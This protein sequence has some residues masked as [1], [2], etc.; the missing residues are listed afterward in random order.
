MLEMAVEPSPSDVR[1]VRSCLDRL[2]R[3]RR[4]MAQF[5]LCGPSTPCAW[6]R[7]ALD[8]AIVS[9]VT[10]AREFQLAE[11]DELLTLYASGAQHPG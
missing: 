4:R 10:L 7:R 1:C 5:G 11:A 2:L 6:H 8:H 3:R 9:Y